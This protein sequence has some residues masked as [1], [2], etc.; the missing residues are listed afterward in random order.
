MFLSQHP[1][2]YISSWCPTPQLITHAQSV[3]SFT[4]VEKERWLG[5]F[6]LLQLPRKICTSCC[7]D[8]IITNGQESRTLHKHFS[9]R[10]EKVVSLR[11]TNYSARCFCSLMFGFISCL[12][13]IVFIVYCV[14][15]SIWRRAQSIVGDSVW[16]CR[17]I[18]HAIWI[19][20]QRQGT[21]VHGSLFGLL[22]AAVITTCR[23]SRMCVR[24]VPGSTT[25]YS[26]RRYCPPPPVYHPH[27]SPWNVFH[28]GYIFDDNKYFLITKITE[29]EFTSII[30]IYFLIYTFIH[31][32][33][34]TFC[35][36]FETKSATKALV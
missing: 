20:R 16:C 23:P 3:Y 10:W 28:N 2:C 9:G 25:V 13:Y 11:A 30:F 34:S 22:R 27:T 7:A 32:F 18:V 33:I 26:S 14:P 36:V 31:S 8:C 5:G 29:K 19:P 17:Y 21:G 1:N 35:F 12:S 4:L 15:L 6:A 24:Y